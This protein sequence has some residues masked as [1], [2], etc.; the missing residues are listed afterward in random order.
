MD[1]G[2]EGLGFGWHV[3]GIY[4]GSLATVVLNMQPKEVKL[5]LE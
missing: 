1:S 3:S 4:Y 2:V 5:R